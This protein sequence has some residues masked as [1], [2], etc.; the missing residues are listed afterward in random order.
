MAELQGYMEDTPTIPLI[1]NPLLLS[2]MGSKGPVTLISQPSLTPLTMPL[3]MWVLP[4]PS[5]KAQQIP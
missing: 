4:G 5:T 3:G 1:P 2:K